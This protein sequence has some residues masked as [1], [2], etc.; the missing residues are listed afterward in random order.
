MGPKSHA[1]KNKQEL[2]ISHSKR[3]NVYSRMRKVQS[4]AERV[5]EQSNQELAL[6][7]ERYNEKFEA[8]R[9]WLDRYRR[10]KEKGGNKGLAEVYQ[11]D[12]FNEYSPEYKNRIFHASFLIKLNLKTTIMIV[13]LQQN[14]YFN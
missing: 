8:A 9:E 4:E 3:E 10:D 5:L 2:D 12:S 13:H 11:N 7:S 14:L 6:R 1:P